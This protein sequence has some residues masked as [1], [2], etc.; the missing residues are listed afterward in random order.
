MEKVR[1][2]DILLEQKYPIGTR[3]RIKNNLPASKS[4]FPKGKEAY[5][6]YTYAYAYGKSSERDTKTYCLDIDGIGRISWY[7]E[8]EL[9]L[10]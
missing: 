9:E 2:I 7:D 1:P 5:V 4:H 6:L 3:V 8:D 10:I